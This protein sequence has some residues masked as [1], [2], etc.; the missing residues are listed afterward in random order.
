MRSRARR[1]A[2]VV[3]TDIASDIIVGRYQPGSALPTEQVLGERFNVSRTVV[4]EALARL[5]GCGLIEVRHGLGSVVLERAHWR[6]IDPDL[7]QIRTEAGL[8]NDLLPDLFDIRRMVELEVA[9]RAARQRTPE[10]LAI[11]AAIMETQRQ[12]MGDPEAY[13]AAD[14]AFHDALIGAS[15]NQLL[16]VLI[17]PISQ[18]WRIGSMVT[19]RRDPDV[20]NYSMQGHEEIFAAVSAGDAAAARAAM[21]RHLDRFEQRLAI[22]LQ[23]GNTLGGSAEATRLGRLAELANDQAR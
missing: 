6:E 7:L 13:N 22:A 1:R 16:R 20:V 12:S 2:D 23:L 5:A 15:G 9:D 10:D 17:A 14:I 21:G 11:L 18:V 19:M 4:R 8:I 3:V